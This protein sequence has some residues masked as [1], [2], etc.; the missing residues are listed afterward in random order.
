GFAP[1]P[2]GVAGR[3]ELRDVEQISENFELGAT[4]QPGKLRGDVRNVGCGAFRPDC[5]RGVVLGD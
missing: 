5:W 2:F 3:L 1:E 4:R